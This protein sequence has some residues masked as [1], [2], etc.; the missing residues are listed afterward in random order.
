MIEKLQNLNHFLSIRTFDSIF[1]AFSKQ[2]MYMCESSQTFNVQSLTTVT[3]TNYR[4]WVFCNHRKWLWSHC[5][6]GLLQTVSTA[7]NVLAKAFG[8]RRSHQSPYRRHLYPA[9]VQICTDPYGPTYFPPLL[10]TK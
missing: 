2:K 9:Q 6:I 4:S 8:S 10:N 7:I 3:I 5:K 1:L